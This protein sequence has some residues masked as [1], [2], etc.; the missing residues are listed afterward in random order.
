MLNL[1]I[2]NKTTPYFLL[3]EILFTVEKVCVLK[4]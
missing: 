4:A 2:E 3:K 1:V